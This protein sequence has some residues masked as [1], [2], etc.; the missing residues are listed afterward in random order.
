VNNHLGKK[1]GEKEK[2]EESKSEK[3]K[4]KK[5]PKLSDSGKMPA[6]KVPGVEPTNNRA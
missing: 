3:G 4:G 5:F 6:I 1:G 2:N